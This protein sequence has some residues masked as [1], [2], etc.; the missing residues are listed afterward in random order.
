MSAVRSSSSAAAQKLA[1]TAPEAH[2]DSRYR[3]FLFVLLFAFY[4]AN[5]ASTLAAY[6]LPAHG[7]TPSTFQWGRARVTLGLSTYRH[8]ARTE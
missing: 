8:V 6:P 2:V 1:A 4:S 5:V 7:A 3:G